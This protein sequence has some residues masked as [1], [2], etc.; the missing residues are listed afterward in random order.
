[1]KNFCKQLGKL[2]LQQT[3]LGSFG[4]KRISKRWKL[5]IL[6]VVV[7]NKLMYGLGTMQLPKSDQDR[8]AAFQMKMLR[9]VLNVPPVIDEF[10]LRAQD[11]HVKLS[12]KWKQRNSPY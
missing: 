6:D 7:M 4:Q 8:I 9:R 12:D 11:Q 10:Q 3:K 1:M 2:M 5:T